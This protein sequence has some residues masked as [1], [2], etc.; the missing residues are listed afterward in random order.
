MLLFPVGP[1]RFVRARPCAVTVVHFQPFFSCHFSIVPVTSQVAQLCSV[2]KSLLPELFPDP[3]HELNPIIC[4]VQSC[5]DQP[6]DNNSNASKKA[7][8]KSSAFRDL[9][10]ESCVKSGE[11]FCLAVSLQDGTLIYVSSTITHILGYSKDMLLGQCIM[12]FLYP[13]DRITFA[14]QLSEGLNSRFNEDAKGICHS[15]SQSTFLCRLRQYQSLK[16]GYGIS[17]KKVH[18]RPF[19][20]SVYI[21]DVIVDDVS[22]ENASTAMCLIVTAVPIQTAYKVPDEIPAMTCFSTRHTASCH[23][24]H[25][26]LSAAPYLGFLPQDML[27]HSVFD[28]YRVDDMPHLKDIYELV[29]KEQGHSFRSKPY[30]FRAFNGSFVTLET[31]W[32]CFIN[33]WTRKLEFVVGQHRVLKGPKDPDVFKEAPRDDMHVPEEIYK[34]SLRIQEE[35]K[36]ILSQTLKPHEN[37]HLRQRSNKRRKELASFVSSLVDEMAQQKRIDKAEEQ[38]LNEGCTCSD[39]G[40]VVMGEIS[41][42]QELHDSDPSSESP[43]NIQEIR[44]QENIERFFASHPKTNSSDGPGEMKI[45][46]E[47][48]QPD[49]RDE[50]GCK[51]SES[52]ESSEG[53]PTSE[54]AMSGSYVGRNTESKRK[55]SSVTTGDSGH[56]SLNTKDGPTT[57]SSCGSRNGSAGGDSNENNY[58]PC[59]PLTEE[60]LQQHNR[61]SHKYHH[62]ATNGGTNGATEDFCKDS[63]RFKRSGSPHH[64]GVHKHTKASR[65]S[66]A[67]ASGPSFPPLLQ[68]VVSSQP[69]NVAAAAFVPNLAIP[70]YTYVPLNSSHSTATT[71][72]LIPV[73]YV[74]GVPLYPSLPAMDGQQSK[75]MWQC[76]ALPLMPLWQQPPT[77]PVSQSTTHDK[78]NSTNNHSSD[79]AQED[80]HRKESQEKVPNQPNQKEGLLRPAEHG[81]GDNGR[82]QGP[83]VYKQF[84]KFKDS[85]EVRARP[86]EPK[87]SQQDDSVSLS[88]ESS[89]FEKSENSEN[90]ESQFSSEKSSE[91]TD[92]EMK[93]RR[94]KQHRAGLRE[95][96]W[97]EG[98]NMNSDVVYRYQLAPGDLDS[99]LKSDMNKLQVLQQPNLVNEQLSALR[100]ELESHDDANGSESPI[101]DNGGYMHDVIYAM[102]EDLTEEIEEQ[103]RRMLSVIDPDF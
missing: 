100:L 71:P 36:V 22:V 75:G 6:D 72:F 77:Q 97:T 49:N 27:G 99:V 38:L 87:D 61:I 56:E 9:K 28:F 14:N 93:Q 91:D 2:M 25:V 3:L 92:T 69:D 32:S 5:R 11:G 60:V 33:P 34:E 24:S 89:F 52:P 98:V 31:E 85:N 4:C 42:H 43:P 37:N 82:L 10:N 81:Q 35:I 21:K 47:Q 46:N 74:G 73:M 39:Q 59:P 80:N 51:S 13:R 76:G 70:T 30:H 53:K 16:F 67:D 66:H 68:G 64:S 62:H 18:Y 40:S 1:S 95:P 8:I 101:G 41:P 7:H 57:G 63:H 58:P 26:D 65:D 50:E 12:N 102:E 94:R 90:S 29:I 48:I 103:E 54:F 78:G 88:F 45:D 86:V 55:H 84:G 15:R 83:A 44:Y 17:D 79:K 96:Y 20:M 19:Q 23:Y